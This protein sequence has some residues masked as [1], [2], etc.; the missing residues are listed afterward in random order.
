MPFEPAVPLVDVGLRVRESGAC[1][2]VSVIC[3]CSIAPFRLALI[4]TTVFVV[5]APVGMLMELEK[6]P[7]ATVVLEGTLTRAGLLLERAT[8]VPPAGAWP[9]NITISVG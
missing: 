1:C 4:V 9:F 6:L 7:G 8:P 2:G 3:V 5:T